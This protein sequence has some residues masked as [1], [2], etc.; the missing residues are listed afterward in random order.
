[1]ATMAKPRP[2]NPTMPLGTRVRKLRLQQHM[3]LESLANECELTRSML[4]KIENGRASPSIAAVTRIAASL[5]VGVSVL[6]GEGAGPTTVATFA[7]ELDGGWTT[8]EK[9]YG[10]APLVAGRV[11]KIMQPMLFIARRGKIRPGALHHGGEEFVYVL[12]GRMRYTVGQATR[13]L[14]PGDS[15]YFDA[16]EPHDLRPITAMVKYLAVMATRG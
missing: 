12:E 13:E 10:Y 4:S 11:E 16:T 6:L 3:T 9:G 5:G 7:A 8:T 2:T 15:L 14:G 1:M